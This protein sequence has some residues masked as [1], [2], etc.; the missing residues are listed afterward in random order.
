MT[1]TAKL[2]MP[3]PGRA[4]AQGI[5]PRGHRGAGQQGRRPEE[6]GARDSIRP[7]P[8]RRGR[9]LARTG[10]FLLPQNLAHVT[11][12]AQRALDVLVG[13]GV[14]KEQ[15]HLAARALAGIAALDP[16]G[17]V[18][19]HVPA[20]GAADLNGVVHEW[21]LARGRSMPRPGGALAARTATRPLAPTTLNKVHCR[22][23][24]IGE[25]AI[26]AGSRLRFGE[27]QGRKTATPGTGRTE[28]DDR[29]RGGAL[30]GSRDNEV[31]TLMARSAARSRRELW[32]P[33][34]RGR[35]LRTDWSNAAGPRRRRAGT[36]PAASRA[37]LRGRCWRGCSA[38]FRV[39]GPTRWRR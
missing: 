8:A 35:K 38:A 27:P 2:F 34:M 3:Q 10:E 24:I 11:R 9:C 23:G 5:P 36:R 29:S 37:A 15:H 26:N 19:E 7:T 6:L 4:P 25:R 30:R 1:A 31:S 20:T 32:G 22:A 21:L 13:R 18:P 17:A 39:F 14:I 16:A 28:P 12:R 33:W